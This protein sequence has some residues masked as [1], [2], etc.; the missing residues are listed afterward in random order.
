MNLYQQMEVQVCTTK[1]SSKVKEDEKW[2]LTDTMK[3]EDI[4]EGIL[5]SVLYAKHN[6]HSI[7]SLLLNEQNQ[8]FFY[9]KKY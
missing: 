8:H 2:K 1:L 3:N 6:Q 5:H 4:R 9:F 7:F